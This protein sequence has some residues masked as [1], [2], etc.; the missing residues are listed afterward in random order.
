MRAELCSSLRWSLC[1]SCPSNLLVSAT[2]TPLPTFISLSRKVEEQG[3]LSKSMKMVV[4][5]GLEAIAWTLTNL[6]LVLRGSFFVVTRD[7][8]S[9]S[10]MRS[11]KFERVSF[12]VLVSSFTNTRSVNKREAVLSY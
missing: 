5:K 12:S 4:A 2:S 9:Y 11:K 6:A 7:Q 8:S 1:D 10:K 3:L